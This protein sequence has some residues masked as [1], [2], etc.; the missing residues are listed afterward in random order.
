MYNHIKSLFNN[1]LRFRLHPR[2]KMYLINLQRLQLQLQR[3]L[4]YPCQD[5]TEM[6]LRKLG[7][8]EINDVTTALR[9]SVTLMLQNKLNQF[10]LQF[11]KNKCF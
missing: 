9:K 4:A 8:S 5:Q 11:N 6:D 7:K 3:I 1:I 2:F 10:K